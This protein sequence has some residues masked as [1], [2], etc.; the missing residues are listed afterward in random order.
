MSFCKGEVFGRFGDPLVSLIY[1]DC[2]IT[3]MKADEPGMLKAVRYRLYPNST[4]TKKLESN[5][6]LCRGAYNTLIEEEIL[7]VSAG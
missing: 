6:S 2:M 1:H 4:Q 7:R 5:L 3:I